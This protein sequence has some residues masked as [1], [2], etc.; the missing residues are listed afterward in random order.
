MSSKEILG[1]PAV[2]APIEPVQ[3]APTASS[4]GLPWHL[5]DH[6]YGYEINVTPVGWLFKIVLDD[7][8]GNHP[9]D[10]D[11]PFREA[12]REHAEFMMLAC[13]SFHATKEALEKIANHPACLYPH[14][15]SSPYLIGVADGHRLA[16]K[17]ARAALALLS[18]KGI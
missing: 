5:R 9:R 12:Q 18:T 2:A 1:V 8:I 3:T 4:L 11:E 10:D 14:P 16:A 6:E 13:N 15:T 7:T 17:I